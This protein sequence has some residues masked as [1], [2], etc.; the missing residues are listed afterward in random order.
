VARG[1]SGADRLGWIAVDESGVAFVATDD[2]GVFE[3]APA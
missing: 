3:F 2:H 1:G